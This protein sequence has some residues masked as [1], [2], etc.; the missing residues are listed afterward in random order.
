MTTFVAID[1]ETADT[2]KDSACA[3]GLVRVQD[4]RVAAE[5]YHLIR[6]PRSTMMFQ[7]LHGISWSD[8]ADKPTFREL[9]PELEAFIGDAEFLVAHNA[10]F[11]RGVLNACCDSH[12]LSAPQIPF[13]CTVKLARQVWDVRPTK[14]PNVCSHL[15]IRLKHH[16]AA[17]DSL[18]CAQIVMHATNAG[19]D[20]AGA[21][22]GARRTNARKSRRSSPPVMPTPTSYNHVEANSASYRSPVGNG[23]SAGEPKK[24]QPSY[25]GIVVV[26]LVLIWVISLL[27]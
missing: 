22:L 7:Y 25:L 13:L 23:S 17:S 15:N 21:F 11:D 9:W 6:P 1:F 3:I 12:G 5:A 2:G 24:S 10:P 18:A 19:A 26:V 4:N 14:L 8:V 16:H 20:L 27:T